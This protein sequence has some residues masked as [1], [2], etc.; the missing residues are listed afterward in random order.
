MGFYLAQLLTGLANASS[1]FL[2]ASGLSIIFGVTR[3][4]NF[5][6]GSFYMLGAY[7]A[8]TLVTTLNGGILGYWFSVLVAALIVGGIGLLVEL[9]ILRRI[10]RAPELFQ[11][12]A[13]FGVVLIVQDA[14]LAIWGA[15]DLL[16]PRAPGL[17]RAVRLMGEPI[18]EYDLALIAIGPAVLA[19]IWLLFHRTRWG[20][21][22]RAATQDR[23]MVGA[24]GV[25]QAWLFSAAFV[26]GS[27]L[28]G[29]GG[30]LQIPREAVSLQMDLSIIGEAFVVVVI[31]G[32]GSVTGAFVA[33]VL[34]SVLNAFAI[35][36]FPQIS[37]VLP[38]VV[39]AVVLI[40]R[41]YGL[42][43]RP[44][45]EHGGAEEPEQPLRLLDQK[46]TMV[47]LALVAVLGFSPAVVSDFTTILLVDVMV[48]T[49]FAV[50]LHFMMGIGGM[51]SFGHAAYFGV[52]AYAAAMAVKLL[53][54]G[55]LPAM[56]LG[57]IAAAL[58]AIF[59]GWFCVR[60]SGVYLAM[61]TMAAAQILW[62]VT[63]QWQDVTGGDDGILG[64]WPA[65]WAASDRVFFYVAFILCLGGIWVLRRVAHSPFG[66]TLR[67][68][69]DSRIRAE[70]I[71]V[72]T[73]FHQWMG[74]TLAG[75][76]A[77]M[78]G[79]VFVFSKG[80]VFPDALSIGHS[81]D[82]LIMVLLGGIHALGGPVYGA[83]AM[84]LIEDW[85]SRLDYWRF[86]F[87]GIILTVVL[88]APDGIAGGVRR[89]GQLV[90]RDAA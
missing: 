21:L 70:A 40:V 66:Y 64:V 45:S 31:G 8:Y 59:F 1:L 11:L 26:L 83:M 84:V 80:S 46:S 67:G 19:A 54:W 35:L 22:V 79:A 3:I 43:G 73:R 38:F 76:L 87:G 44:G 85:V 17:D 6:H 13:T 55:M 89:L 24:L 29:L 37:I 34:I 69:R 14:T 82:G 75:T 25:N 15:E 18:P 77:G 58:A 9:T 32:M 33:A 12:V 4:V 65:K 81:I 62:G 48:A 56:A 74:F 23:E 51:V 30:A 50:S 42:F 16:G 90:R 27:A 39:M 52:G 7:L 41:P 88:L 2:I 57:P 86:I 20:I 53:G 63:F 28:A 10:Y 61:L 36:I 71:G 72:D 49:L 60:L 47:L 68:I 5:A 78:A